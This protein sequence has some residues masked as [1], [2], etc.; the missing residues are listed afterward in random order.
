[1]PGTGC[2]FKEDFSPKEEAHVHICS[3]VPEPGALPWT[4]RAIPPFC[5]E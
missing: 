1:M 3:V 2:Y 4:L 5:L